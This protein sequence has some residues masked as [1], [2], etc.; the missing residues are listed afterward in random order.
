MNKNLFLNS[1]K[2]ILEIM[3]KSKCHIVHSMSRQIALDLMAPLLQ[4][5]CVELEDFEYMEFEA[6]CWVDGLTISSL[7]L[8]CTLLHDVSQKGISAIAGV[9]AVWAENKISQAMRL[10]PL[11]ASLSS[12]ESSRGFSSLII[13]VCTR[14]LVFQRNPI[15]LA[16]LVCHV[17]ENESLSCAMR[18]DAAI[19]LL[20][21]ARSLLNFHPEDGPARLELLERLLESSLSSKNTLLTV[22]KLLNDSPQSENLL[23]EAFQC[24]A[25]LEELQVLSKFLIHAILISY[26]KDDVSDRCWALLRF[27][28][29]TILLVSYGLAYC[30]FTIF[31]RL[32]MC[33]ATSIFPSERQGIEET[34]S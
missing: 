10:S 25:T 4:S 2:V 31:L 20:S 12:V 1:H 18:S 29:P 34:I 5:R 24:P 14:C 23:I 30:Q 19:P 33:F 8:F 13:Q 21:Y 6:A 22:F 16:A 7:P 28:T 11:I 27:T 3:L 32:M 17:G 26:G 15:P 9:S